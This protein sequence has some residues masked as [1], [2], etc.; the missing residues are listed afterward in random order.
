MP[1]WRS[2]DGRVSHS[3]S[4]VAFSASSCPSRLVRL[5][6]HCVVDS[7]VLF[8]KTSARRMYRPERAWS[9]ACSWTSSSDVPPT[10][11][12]SD[13]QVTSRSPCG[14]TPSQIDLSWDSSS[15]ML[16][17]DAAPSAVLRPG[18]AT[19][20]ALTARRSSLEDMVMGIFSIGTRTVGHM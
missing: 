6:T 8:A 7:S 16:C 3:Q 11:K 17:A 10:W 14:I 1:I 2:A 20:S 15:D 9:C 13:S 5:A 19:G 18:C 12:K 4:I